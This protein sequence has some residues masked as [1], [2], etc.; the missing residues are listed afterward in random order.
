MR[1]L[2][3]YILILTILQHCNRLQA[4]GICNTYAGTIN[5]M[6]ELKVSHSRDEETPEAKARWFQ[7]LTLEER[8]GYICFITQLLLENNPKV[9]KGRDVRPIQGRIQVLSKP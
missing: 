3:Y 8:M 4:G 2:L 9:L 1:L 6:L 5:N 7:S